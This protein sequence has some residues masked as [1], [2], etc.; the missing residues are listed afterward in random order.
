MLTSI[1][2]NHRGM[3]YGLLF[4]FINGFVSIVLAIWFGERKNAISNSKIIRFSLFG[5]ML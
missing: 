5:T 2:P 3:A 4:A 1:T